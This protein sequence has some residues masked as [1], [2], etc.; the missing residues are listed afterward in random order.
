M[1]NKWM[2]A[3]VAM[4][5]GISIVGCG[6]GL[7]EKKQ[8]TVGKEIT[9]QEITEFYFT[10]DSSAYQPSFLRYRLYTEDGQ[11][12]FHYEV[13]EGDH[14][15]L[16]EEDTTDSLTKQLSSDQWSAFFETLKGGNVIGRSEDTSSGGFGPWLYLYWKK[17]KGTYQ[18]FQFESPEKQHAFES[19]C[20]EM[21]SS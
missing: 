16:T 4:L 8:Y 21:S 5:A 9:L 19:M 14:W 2:I 18:V 15:P 10:Y 11:Y 7:F 12:Y 20:K 17:D 6:T 3:A 13:R 1:M